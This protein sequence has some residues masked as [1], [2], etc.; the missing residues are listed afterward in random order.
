[1]GLSFGCSRLSISPVA[2]G[3]EIGEPLDGV[4]ELDLLEIRGV[5]ENPIGGL[6]ELAVFLDGGGGGGVD[7]DAVA[8]G[9]HSNVFDGDF[10]RLVSCASWL[11]GV[12][13]SFLGKAFEGSFA[14]S[15]EVCFLTI[16]GGGSLFGNVFERPIGRVGN[17]GAFP[18]SSRRFIS[19]NVSMEKLESEFKGDGLDDRVMLS[20][21]S[22]SDTSPTSPCSFL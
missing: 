18:S 4:A 11:Y 3:V 16:G 1:M 20:D 13:G 7:T 22:N 14:W 5:V 15:S 9:E 10:G 2:T 21:N 17:F 19:D 8:E 12:G 6:T